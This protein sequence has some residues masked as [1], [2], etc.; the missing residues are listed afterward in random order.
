MLAFIALLV[1]VGWINGRADEQRRQVHQFDSII[2]KIWQNE[3]SGNLTA[4]VGDDGQAFGPLQIHRVVLSDVN[5]WYGTRYTVE[6]IKDI[7]KAKQVARL[8]IS[9]WLDANK[10][11]IAARIFNG[12]PRG[13]EKQATRDYW[14]KI[15][16]AGK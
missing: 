11:E 9:K 16:R 15:E 4:P 14:A 7:A 1:Y 8:Y 2:D 5:R 13:W 6:D 12:G 10:D 3:S